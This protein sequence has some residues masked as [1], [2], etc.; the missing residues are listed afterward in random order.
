[1]KWMIAVVMLLYSASSAWAAGEL[2]IDSQK[3]HMDPQKNEVIFSGDVHL[4]R[5]DF[6]LLCDELTV[7]YVGH[8]LQRALAKGHVRIVQGEKRGKADSAVFEKR[9]NTIRLMGHASIED[10][11]GVIR[12][13]EIIHNI[14]S[15]ETRVLQKKGERVHLHINADA[16]APEAP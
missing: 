9:K 5:D 4:V 7:F 8:A 16:K 3:M 11:D 14:T 1:M 15:K 13:H 10:A 12:G 6:D 2:N